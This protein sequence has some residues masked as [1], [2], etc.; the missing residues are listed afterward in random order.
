VKYA[1]DK[2]QWLVEVNTQPNVFFVSS[3][4]SYKTLDDFRLAKGLKA[5]GTSAKGFLAIAPSVLFEILG[6]DGKVVTG[7][8]GARAVMLAVAQR[9]LDFLVITG[10]T[11]LPSVA[12]GDLLPLFAIPDVR[13]TVYPDVPTMK[14][15]GVKV[16]QELADVHS[17]A[18]WAANFVATQPG[19]PQERIEYLR[20]VFMKIGKRKDVQ[21]EMQKVLKVWHDFIPGEELSAYMVKIKSNQALSS[22]LD[23]IFAK[24]MKA[25]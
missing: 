20:N 18:S 5:G 2:F 8:G 25:K 1:V 7:Y 23:T 21:A 9:E 11:A 15:L 17:L 19:V 24:Y 22:Q 13:S 12:A 10:S 16:P 3:K 14:E 4:S 6:L